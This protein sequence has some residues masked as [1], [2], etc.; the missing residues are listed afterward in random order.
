MNPTVAALMVRPR[1]LHLDEKHYEVDGEPIS[2]SLFDFG[3][4][5]FHNAEYL[6]NSGK[7]GLFL[8][9]K[10]RESARGQMVE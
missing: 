9:S 6:A 2:G 3:L 7:G 8:S 4:Y 10:T 5:L 1:G